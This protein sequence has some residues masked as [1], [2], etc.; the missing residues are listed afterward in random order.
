MGGGTRSAPLTLD[1]FVHDRCSAVHPLAVAAPALGQLD[2]GHRGVEWLHPE[3]QVA[4][5]LEGGRAGAICRSVDETAAGL[6][7]DA[8]RYRRSMA[9]LVEAADLLTGAVLSPLSIPPAR[10]LVPLARFGTGAAW[11]A[12]TLARRR[13][14]TDEA[15]GPGGRPV[16]PLDALAARAGHRRLRPVPGGAGPR[17]GL[18]GG[19]G[20]LPGH[21]RRPGGR[22]RGPRRPGHHRLA[23]GL[24]RRAPPGPGHP[25]R[26]LP[27]CPARPW[28]AT[29][30]RPLRP[31][32]ATATATAPGVFKVDWALDGPIPWLAGRRPAGPPRCTW[33]APSTRWWRRGRGHGRPPSPSARSCWWPSPRWSTP[34]GTRGQHV[35]WAYCHVPNGSTVDMT[36][37]AS[38]PRSSASPPGSRDLILA[39]ATSSPAQVE[40]HDANYV[41]GDI[42]CGRT[43]LTQLV[44]RPVMSPSPWRTPLPGVYLCSSATPPGPGRARHVRL[45]R[46]PGRVSDHR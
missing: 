40:G 12:R 46:G 37:R 35:G 6:G 43:D 30:C 21:R 32:P 5:P 18:A 19:P 23:G 39:R 14:D 17:R 26:R 28:P 8:G 36:E 13:F 20:R 24:A 11:P 42:A 2:L 22:R 41:G 45:A 4:H 9:P 33:A 38:R 44:T 16:G 34:P 27:H 25:A 15:R 1:G 10:A 7:A 3:V 31:R 29:G